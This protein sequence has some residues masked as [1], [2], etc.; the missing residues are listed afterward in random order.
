MGF[1]NDPAHPELSRVHKIDWMA[2]HTKKLHLEVDMVVLH[3]GRAIN[4]D[5]VSGALWDIRGWLKQYRNRIFSWHIKDGR[6]NSPTPT[7]NTPYVQ[8]IQRTPTFLDALYAGEGQIGKGY[9][10]DPDPA[11]VGYR[12]IWLEWDTGGQN[13]YEIESNSSV[14]PATGP[15]ADPGRSLRHAKISARNLLALNR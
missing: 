1:F 9:P 5:P 13:F 4:P 15:T 7:I 11:V 10:F 6:R 14:G 2:E 8:T 3:N 12:D